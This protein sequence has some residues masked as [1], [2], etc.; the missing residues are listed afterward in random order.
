MR[1]GFTLL[2]VMMVMVISAMVAVIGIRH[3]NSPG[4]EAQRRSCLMT[5]EM[6]QHH[7]EAYQ[8]DTG[9]PV[10]TTLREIANDRYAGTTLPQCPVSGAT[11]TIRGGQVQCSAHPNN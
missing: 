11:Y 3:L 8:D 10:T 2:E 6:L 4:S 1:T 9:T 5:R 7:V